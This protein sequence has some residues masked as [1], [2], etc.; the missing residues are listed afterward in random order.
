MRVAI[1]IPA[2][3][4]AG[5]IATALRSVMRQTHADWRAVV[6]DDGSC[7]STGAIAQEFT[8]RRLHVVRQAN[9]GVSAARNAGLREVDGDAVLFLDAD[10]WLAPDALERLVAAL[11]AAPWAVASVGPY[12]RVGTDGRAGRIVRPYG[13]DLL[14]E[15]L[16]RNRFLNGGHLLIRREAIGWAGAFRPDLAFGEDWEYWSRLALFGPFAAD[17]GDEPVLHALDRADGAYRRLAADPAAFMACLS[18]IHA[19]PMLRDRLGPATRT[20][21]RRKAEAEA[22]WILAREMV[23]H[24]AWREGGHWL[25]R[26]ATA[27]PT[28]R[29]LVRLTALC[30]APG[31]PP[32]WRGP[33]RP[34]AG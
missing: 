11:R 9:Q 33:F 12:A 16:V 28:L 26:S 7:D 6:V 2:H 25:W 23:R 14:R 10:D 29:A 30:L 24:G 13:G 32:S 21:L 8:N 4:V 18:A 1:I 20:A 15:L 31:L 17:R 19:N 27:N 34:Y 5:H 3:D 22:G